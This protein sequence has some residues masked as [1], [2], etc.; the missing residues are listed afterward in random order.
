MRSPSLHW[1]F[2]SNNQL[3]S[4][5]PIIY[6]FQNVITAPFCIIV[7]DCLAC[8]ENG[9]GES[10]NHIFDPQIISIR[11]FFVAAGDRIQIPLLPKEAIIESLA[12]DKKTGRG[13]QGITRAIKICLCRSLQQA[14]VPCGEKKTIT[15]STIL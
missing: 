2:L 14:L 11:G 13:K 6:K 12:K 4:C 5:C 1:L 3:F 15:E 7:R 8:F 9:I 10:F